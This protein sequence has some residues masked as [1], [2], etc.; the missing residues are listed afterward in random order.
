LR[1]RSDVYPAQMGMAMPII[2]ASSSRIFR[3][4][5]RDAVRENFFGVLCNQTGALHEILVT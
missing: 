2:G 4:P 3:Q 1:N 5:T